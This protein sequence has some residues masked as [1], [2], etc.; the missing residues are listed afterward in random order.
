MNKQY[1]LF[2]VWVTQH[3]AALQWQKKD[4]AKMLGVSQPYLTDLLNGRRPGVHHVDRIVQ[5]IQ[6]AEAEQ[7][8]LMEPLKE[9][10]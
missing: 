1:N 6:E 5:L 10:V 9:V 3:L 7:K 8:K 4:L 2:E